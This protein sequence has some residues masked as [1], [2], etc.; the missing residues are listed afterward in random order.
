MQKLKVKT[1]RLKSKRIARTY[2]VHHGIASLQ[3]TTKL[4]TANRSHAR[5]CNMYLRSLW[6]FAWEIV[7][8]CVSAFSSIDKLHNNN[9][10][11]VAHFY[12][13]EKCA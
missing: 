5:A 7:M 6:D 2:T 9:R 13:L 12:R 4:A 11:I 3:E 1:F 8:T 10:P